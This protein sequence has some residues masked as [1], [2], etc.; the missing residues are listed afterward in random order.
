[1]LTNGLFDLQN[2]DVEQYEFFER[3]E[4][5]DFNWVTPKFLA[6]A[7]PKDE[8]LPVGFVGKQTPGSHRFTSAYSSDNLIK[9]M[10]ANNLKT[11]IRLN[12]KTY[13]RQKFVDAGI[14]HIELY[15]ADGSNPP[16][17][18]IKRFLDIC[19]SREGICQ[20]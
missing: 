12:N 14:E 2:F 16:D 15:F 6:L 13:D 17:T 19:E 10:I 8:Q 1:M 7:C 5:G 3:V 4:N 11:I 18:I 20:M 9:F